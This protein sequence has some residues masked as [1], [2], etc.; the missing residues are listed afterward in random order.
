[1]NMELEEVNRMYQEIQAYIDPTF[2]ELKSRTETQQRNI[3]KNYA[4]HNQ[5][6]NLALEKINSIL[7]N[8]TTNEVIEGYK[9][10]GRLL[11]RNLSGYMAG[12]FNHDYIPTMI[13][14]IKQPH[15]HTAWLFLQALGNNLGGEVSDLVIEALEMEGLQETALSIVGQLNL[16]EALPQ[17]QRLTENHNATIAYL[18]SET[19][20]QL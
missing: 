17:I 18:A 10:G 20:K 4:Q 15:L 6:Y 16:V 3:Q 14:A 1:M 2:D 13:N 12:H 7:P 8:L 5:V 19:I 9:D 11:Q